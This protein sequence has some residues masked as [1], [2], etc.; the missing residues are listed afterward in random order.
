[1]LFINAS[2]LNC[3]SDILLVYDMQGKVIHSEPLRVQNGYYTRD[4]SMIGYAEGMYLI[5]IQTEKER[6]TKKMMVE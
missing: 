3:K 5:T 2:N 1:M 6:L 4:L